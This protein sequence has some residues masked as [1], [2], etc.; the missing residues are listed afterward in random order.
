MWKINRV[1]YIETFDQNEDK[2]MYACSDAN[3]HIMNMMLFLLL[4]LLCSNLVRIE[5][6]KKIKRTIEKRNNNLSTVQNEDNVSHDIF[7]TPSDNCYAF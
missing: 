2:L 3:E 1:Y 5:N 4:L 6:K 7:Q